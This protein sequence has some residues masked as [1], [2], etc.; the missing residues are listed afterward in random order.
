[1]RKK[2]E[3]AITA[4]DAVKLLATIGGYHGT[5]NSPPPGHQII[6]EGYSDLRRLIEGYE[7]GYPAGYA[8][9]VAAGIATVTRFALNSLRARGRPRGGSG[10]S[11][12]A[13]ELEAW[14]TVTAR[15]GRRPGSPAPKKLLSANANVQRMSKNMSKAVCKVFVFQ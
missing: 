4:K 3:P 5:S 15:D 14:H 2:T 7:M 6:W 1:M 10:M 8:A 9:G 13:E 11:V 12:M